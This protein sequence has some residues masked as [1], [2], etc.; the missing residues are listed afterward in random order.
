M[1]QGNIIKNEVGDALMPEEIMKMNWLV[2]NIVGEIPAI[3]DLKD[4]AKSIVE[5][6]VVTD[7]TVD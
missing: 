4:E 6:K 2:D 3:D 5:L 1:A 7:E